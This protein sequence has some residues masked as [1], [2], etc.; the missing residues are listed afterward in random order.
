MTLRNRSL[1]GSL[2]VELCRISP[3]LLYHYTSSV[4]LQGI[5]TSKNIWASDIRYLNDAHEFVYGLDQLIPELTKQIVDELKNEYAE[6][7]LKIILGADDARYFV[8]CF[9]EDGDLLSQWRGYAAPGGFSL[10][11]DATALL[12]ST[13]PVLPVY[14]GASAARSTDPSSQSLAEM[15]AEGFNDLFR[16]F[17]AIT[18]HP[19][20]KAEEEYLAKKI[21]EFHAEHLWVSKLMCAI[22]KDPSFREEREWRMVDAR[23]PHSK[24]PRKVNFRQGPLGL[25]PYVELGLALPDGQLPL[26]E[27]IVGPGPHAE[28]RLSA[29]EFML[30]ELGYCT[31]AVIP[32]TVPYRT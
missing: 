17:F 6:P 32:S 22:L 27:I 19:K 12:D 31:V 23:S 10:G 3:R 25:T 11:F 29:I 30:A 7:A 15:A 24:D 21:H 4:G 9:C 18:E 5:L 8:A 20:D 13:P 26:R 14:Y 1:W 28:L 2:F 16:E